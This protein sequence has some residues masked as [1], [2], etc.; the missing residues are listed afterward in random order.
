MKWA[1]ITGAILM[2]V[3]QGLTEFLPVSSSGHLVVGSHILELAKPSLLF[4]V[5]LHLGTLLPVL[6]LYRKEVGQMVVALGALPRFSERW[7]EDA[8]LR[9]LVS[10]FIGSI[11]T[12]LLGLGA[13]DLFESL[14]SSTKAVS[15]TFAITGCILM[16]TRFRPGYM[17]EDDSGFKTLNWWRAL[18]VGT[19]QG[20]AITPGI[21]RSGSTIAVALLIGVERQ[22]A[23]RLSFL[24]SVPAILGAVALLILKS[25]AASWTW[26]FS[27]GFVASVI[28]GYIAL[29]LVV[30]LVRRGAMHWFALYLWPLSAAL[31]VYTFFR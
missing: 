31:I 14:F 23:A 1:S 5:I 17:A 21:S 22:Y 26:A 16:V 13:Q 15:I 29:R 11:P 19:V 24:M 30:G 20:L 3:I 25:D 18:V 7:Q 9:L 8:G 2:G 4:D 10:V 12:A 27:A 6:W 28:S